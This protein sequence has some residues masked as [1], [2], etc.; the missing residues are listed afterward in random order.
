MFTES[1]SGQTFY[2]DLIFY[3]IPQHK[4]VVVELKAVKYIPEF[5]GNQLTLRF[6]LSAAGH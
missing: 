1:H 4:Y 5:A 2:P 3:H 6:S